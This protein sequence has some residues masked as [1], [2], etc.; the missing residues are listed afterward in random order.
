MQV[1]RHYQFSDW[2][3]HST[4]CPVEKSRVKVT[5]YAAPSRAWKLESV[6][7]TQTQANSEAETAPSVSVAIGIHG[8]ICRSRACSS[9]L[10]ISISHRPTD[11]PLFLSINPEVR[12]RHFIAIS[13]SPFRHKPTDIRHPPPTQSISLLYRATHLALTRAHH[14]DTC[15]CY[16]PWKI[17]YCIPCMVHHPLLRRNQMRLP[18]TA[19]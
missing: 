9:D 12:V 4:Q 3:A 2:K 15:P 6:C 18:R 13:L 14:P 11:R 8:I 5:R 10:V 7:Y 19:F 17:S 1:I 16:N